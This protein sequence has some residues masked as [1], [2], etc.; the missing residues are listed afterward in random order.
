MRP[1]TAVL[2]RV[3]WHRLT[4]PVTRHRPARRPLAVIVRDPLVVYLRSFCTGGFEQYEPLFQ[5]LAGEE[6]TF[7]VAWWWWAGTETCVAYVRRYLLEHRRRHPR[8]RIVSLC[9]TEEERELFARHG[10]DAV[11]CSHNAFVDEGIY[12]PHDVVA[13][14]DAVYDARLRAY[15]R[16]H[17]CADVERL[18]V[19]YTFSTELD[20]WQSVRRGE[21]AILH[22]TFPNHRG[23]GYR[24]LPAAQVASTLARARV[25]LCL[26]EEEGAMYASVQYLLCGLP[27]VT[28]PSR[29]GRD[30]FFDA[31]N[32]L[33]VAPDA[34]SVARGVRELIDRD[35]DPAA[36]RRRALDRMLVHR[37]RFLHLLSG[38]LARAGSP[39]SARD[40]LAAAFSDKLLRSRRLDR[41]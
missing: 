16:H 29:G 17:L 2:P 40:V 10:L 39:L 35:L 36:I 11:H 38:I 1:S 20:R 22:A 28:T 9:N 13:D 25:G 5:R 19:L 26:S 12:R 15:K 23:L 7:L 30:V 14:H 21:R 33:C 27:V 34:R 6:A 41:V 8:H 4:L 24:S 32:A 18:L 31:Q 3:L 37:E